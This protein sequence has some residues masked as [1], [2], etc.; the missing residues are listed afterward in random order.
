MTMTLP[1]RVLPSLFWRFAAE[2]K[3]WPDAQTLDEAI[4][5]YQIAIKD[6][7]DHW[8]PKAVVL[9]A[10][11]VKVV[12]ECWDRAGEHEFEPS[13]TLTADTNDGFTAMGLMLALCNTMGQH[14][15][16]NKRWLG[17]HCF[18]EG[19]RLN[20]EWKDTPSY[21]MYLGS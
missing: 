9:P 11:E 5:A 2:G 12:F 21:F 1:A 19:M 15:Q 4:R 18:F 14:L 8:N 7:D 17:D 20:T 3:V 16:D 10:P 6:N 13:L